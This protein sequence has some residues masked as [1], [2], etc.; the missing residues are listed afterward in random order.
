MPAECLSYTISSDSPHNESNNHKLNTKSTSEYSCRIYTFQQRNAFRRS[1]L[2]NTSMRRSERG[3]EVHQISRD[4]AINQTV[5][6]N[7]PPT[8]EDKFTRDIRS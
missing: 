4:S 7:I 8:R 2:P 6:P 1:V 3:N 5:F